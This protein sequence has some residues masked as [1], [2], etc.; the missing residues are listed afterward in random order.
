MQFKGFSAGLSV[1]GLANSDNVIVE[2]FND[3]QANGRIQSVTN[4]S[5]PTNSSD[6]IPNVDFNDPNFA[7]DFTQGSSKYASIERLLLNLALNHAVVLEKPV[8]TY[9]TS[10]S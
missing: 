6:S 1:Y 7:S 5:M 10:P 3:R 8:N 9:S 2:E 4:T